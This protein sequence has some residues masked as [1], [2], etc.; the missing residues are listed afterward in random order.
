VI[1]NG[2]ICAGYGWTWGG[3]VQGGLVIMGAQ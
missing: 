3:T 2:H 1:A